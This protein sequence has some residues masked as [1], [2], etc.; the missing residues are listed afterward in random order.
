MTRLCSRTIR[1]YSLNAADRLVPSTS[2]SWPVSFDGAGGGV[3]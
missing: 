3:A 2:L 1:V